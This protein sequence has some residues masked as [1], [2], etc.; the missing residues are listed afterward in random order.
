MDESFWKDK[1]VLITGHTGFKGTW[2]T[3]WLEKLGAKVIGYSLKDYPNDILFNETKISSKITDIRGDITDFELLKKTFDVLSP[4][5]VFHLAAQPIVRKSFDDPVDTLKTNILGTINILECI[6]L[7]DSVKVGVIITTDKCYKNVEQIYGYKENDSM[8]GYDPYSCSKGCVELIVDSYRNS[9]F[10]KQNKFIATARAGNVIG[11]GDWAEDRLIPDC[12]KSLK[13]N[14]SIKIRNPESIRPWQHV[15]EPLSGYIL[16]AE[17]MIKEKKYDEA[18]NF[19]PNI[20]SIKNVKEIVNAIVTRWG[21]GQWID[22]SDPNEKHEAKLLNLDISKSYFILNWKPKLEIN[23]AINYT[24][25]WY[26]QSMTEDA[27]PLCIKQIND[28]SSIRNE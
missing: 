2:L 8:G 3:I 9:F 11:G 4:D 16:L 13:E 14:Q 27:Y 18:W 26:R 22:S 24:V 21:N 7:T 15:L 23:Q 19:G 5:I 1:K 6:R 20:Q 17:K 10:K 25:D 12:I 28:Y